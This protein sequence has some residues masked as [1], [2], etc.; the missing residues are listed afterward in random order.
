MSETIG[1]FVNAIGTRLVTF[2]KSAQDLEYIKKVLKIKE[3]SELNTLTTFYFSECSKKDQFIE[4]YNCTKKAL[5]DFCLSRSLGC[6]LNKRHYLIMAALGLKTETT[7]KHL[8]KNIKIGDLFNLFDQTYFVT[9][10][11]KKLTPIKEK[12]IQYYTYQF[13]LP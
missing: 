5:A 7:V 4:K 12:G 9:V 2:E 3:C 10:K 11:L 8:I 1:Y 13:E 6:I